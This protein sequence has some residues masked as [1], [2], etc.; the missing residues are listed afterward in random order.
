M[1][2]TALLAPIDNRRKI[3]LL[4]IFAFITLC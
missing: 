3:I 1:L 2:L 4:S